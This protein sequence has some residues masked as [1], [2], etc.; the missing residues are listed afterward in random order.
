[1]VA[2]ALVGLLGV[3]ASVSA[4]VILN[5]GA[6]VDAA[7]KRLVRS[8]GAIVLFVANLGV[9]DALLALEDAAALELAFCARRVLGY[10]IER[11]NV[12]LLKL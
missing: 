12:I 11:K 10:N 8:V 6:L 2:L 7:V 4:A 5:P 3:D 9:R 1:M